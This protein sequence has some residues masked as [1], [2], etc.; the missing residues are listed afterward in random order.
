MARKLIVWKIATPPV[1]SIELAGLQGLLET[2][3]WPR[4]AR[5]A[6]KFRGRV[7]VWLRVNGFKDVTVVSVKRPPVTEWWSPGEKLFEV[8]PWERPW[9][10]APKRG[11]KN[12]VILLHY[13]KYADC[14]KEYGFFEG[15]VKPPATWFW[16][17]WGTVQDDGTISVN[18][19]PDLEG[20][21]S[22]GN[23]EDVQ[24]LAFPVVYG[25][26]LLTGR[27]WIE[28]LGDPEPFDPKKH[29]G[30]VVA[31][32]CPCGCGAWDGWAW[33]FPYA[34]AV[35]PKDVVGVFRVDFFANPPNFQVALRPPDDKGNFE[36][37]P[38]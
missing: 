6:V 27:V 3:G 8:Q 5:V 29:V 33:E 34:V 18:F 14:G 22:L 1:L 37:R 9:P 31:R 12:P 4:G 19:L 21:R 26:N 11:A 30:M 17:F 2:K 20:W 35:I 10:K 15:G 24:L 13:A 25:S 32:E 38:R 36:W 16:P 28:G 23:P 7:V